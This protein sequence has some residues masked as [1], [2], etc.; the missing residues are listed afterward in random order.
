M[1]TWDKVKA[2]HHAEINL[3][4]PS[5]ANMA[6]NSA[7]CVPVTSYFMPGAVLCAITPYQDRRWTHSEIDM[8]LSLEAIRGFRQTN[9]IVRRQA[10]AFH[11]CVGQLCASSSIR[12][13]A[14]VHVMFPAYGCSSDF[15]ISPDV[16]FK[17]WMKPS[18]EDAHEVLARMWRSNIVF[19][20]L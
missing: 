5:S 2:D 15:Q 19:R 16:T 3:A 18:N 17:S 6:K 7:K 12:W 20:C 14:A 13:V 4:V 9:D 11:I 1:A 8:A 10:F